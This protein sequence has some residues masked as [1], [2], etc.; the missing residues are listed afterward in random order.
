M[1]REYGMAVTIMGSYRKRP[2][3]VQE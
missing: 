3:S 1:Q 2:T